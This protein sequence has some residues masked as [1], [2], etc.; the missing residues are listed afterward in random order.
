MIFGVAPNFNIENIYS[1]VK[2]G[3]ESIF[4][5]IVNRFGKKCT[6]VAIGDGKDEEIAAKK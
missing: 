3:K 5:R 4:Q 2:S 1:A 6:Y